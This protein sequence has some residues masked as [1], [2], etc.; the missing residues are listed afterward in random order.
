MFLIAKLRNARNWSFRSIILESRPKHSKGRFTTVVSK[1]TV[2]SAW[3][4]E[5]I[6]FIG[7]R[8]DPSQEYQLRHDCEDY[9]NIGPIFTVRKQ[10]MRRPFT[11]TRTRAIAACFAM[12][13][14]RVFQREPS[15]ISGLNMF[16]LFSRLFVLCYGSSSEVAHPIDKF[17][18]HGK[19]K[20]DPRG[21]VVQH[22]VNFVE[23][24]L[25]QK[26]PMYC[27]KQPLES[28]HD[29]AWSWN[30]SLGSL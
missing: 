4:S 1:K 22:I 9:Y 8:N 26:E 10:F 15:N 25:E 21:T 13:N 6:F 18:T 14:T 12:V 3:I 16:L 19:Y 30:L 2:V 27:M 17:F 23:R 28:P 24:I 7:F 11:P 5:L 20:I 29:K